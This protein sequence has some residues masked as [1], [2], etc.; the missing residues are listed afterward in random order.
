MKKKSKF[1]LARGQ[2]F[3]P[4]KRELHNDKVWNGFSSGKKMSIA[5]R[6]IVPVSFITEGMQVKGI[7]RREIAWKNQKKKKDKKEK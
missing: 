3:L 5:Q 6:K 4:F 2:K 7:E 1:G